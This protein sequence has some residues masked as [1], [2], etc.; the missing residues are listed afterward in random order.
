MTIDPKRGLI[1]VWM[2]QHSGFPGDGGKSQGVFRKTAEEL[3][4]MPQD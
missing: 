1:M 3:F 4:G 2:V